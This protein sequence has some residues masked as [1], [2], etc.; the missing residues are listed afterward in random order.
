MSDSVKK[1]FSRSDEVG[2]LW[3]L[4]NGANKAKTVRDRNSLDDSGRRPLAR[5]PVPIYRM[6][7]VDMLVRLL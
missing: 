7:D 1:V 4:D 5:A 3:L 2:V 6:R